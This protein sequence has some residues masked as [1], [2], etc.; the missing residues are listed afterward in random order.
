MGKLLEIKKTLELNKEVEIDKTNIVVSV[1]NFSTGMCDRYDFAVT[2]VRK[3]PYGSFAYKDDYPSHVVLAYGVITYEGGNSY[4]NHC[5]KLTYTDEE[6]LDKIL[7]AIQ[8]KMGKS[9]HGGN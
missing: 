8:K 7:C 2:S 5:E 6:E 9:L 4:S 3:I 1:F